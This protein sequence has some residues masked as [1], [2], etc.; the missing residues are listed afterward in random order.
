MLNLNMVRVMSSN[1]T[2]QI[3]LP[4]PDLLTATSQLLPCFGKTFYLLIQ[5]RPVSTNKSI[6]KMV[7]VQISY[8][9]AFLTL[10][11][12]TKITQSSGPNGP[13]YLGILAMS[14]ATN[15]KVLITKRGSETFLRSSDSSRR[16]RSHALSVMLWVANSGQRECRFLR[17]N[18]LKVSLIVHLLMMQAMKS[19]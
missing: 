12:A 2:V 16:G 9:V 10:T 4:R 14:R 6:F 19:R 3:S 8:D 15:D 7:S 5:R 11:Q 18:L 13:R 1:G 17:C